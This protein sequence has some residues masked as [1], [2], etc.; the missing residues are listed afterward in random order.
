[1]LFRSRVDALLGLNG[2]LPALR[3]TCESLGYVSNVRALLTRTDF[4]FNVELRR[5]VGGFLLVFSPRKAVKAG[6]GTLNGVGEK[7]MLEDFDNLPPDMKDYFLT[8]CKPCNGCLECTKKGRNK[9][10]TVCVSHNG[11]QYVLCPL[12]P[13]HL[14][15]APDPQL[16]RRLMTYHE[17]QER[18]AK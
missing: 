7:A 10:F 1:M 3:Q 12:F 14:W 13:R 17:L 18:Y 6:F 5:G 11:R 2:V 9:P 4:S 15:E 8:I 16:V